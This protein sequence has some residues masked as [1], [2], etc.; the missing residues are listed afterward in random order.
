MDEIKE[1]I[2]IARDDNQKVDVI[3]AIQ[4]LANKNIEEALPA[5]KD[6]F[7]HPLT[8][9]DVRLESGRL[10]ATTKSNPVYNLLISHLILRNFSDIIAIIYTL[11]EYR[12][13][14]VYDI[15]IRDYLTFSFEAQLEVIDAIS[16]I[17][18]IQSIEFFSQVYNGEILSPNLK[19]EQIQQLKERAGDALQ[20]QVI[21]I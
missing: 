7:F 9:H 17:E 16:K 14:A 19:H 13:N 11:G 2:Q 4:Y 21:D 3:E 1:L 10:I 6:I 12:D 20:N 15:L 5:L 8:N 18:S